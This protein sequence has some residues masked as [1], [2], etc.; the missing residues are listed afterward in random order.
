[1]PN[2]YTT[3]GGARVGWTNATWPLAKL[4][5]TSD[6][7]T[8]SICLL[9]TYSFTPDQVSVVEK[10]V[11]IPVLGWGIQIHHCNPDCPKRVIFWCLGSPDAILRG[12]RDSGFL[13]TASSSASPQ[14]RGIA[15][16][17][18]AIITAVAVWNA[19]FFLDFGR[20]GGVPSQPG[21]LLLGPLIFAFAL[22]VGTF[23]LPMLQGI[24][25]KP[26][27]SV[28]EI[29]PFLRLLAIVSGFLLV[30]FSILLATGA[31]PNPPPTKTGN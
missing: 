27:R 30:A 18:S 17:W 1:M 10:Y 7:L 19:L 13:P 29:R 25:L 14:H 21:P 9:G 3:T 31:F 5:A 15:M 23:N 20:F 8:V 11:M 28:G 12:I 2:P 26:G 6:R 22:S 16:R 24:V 4:S